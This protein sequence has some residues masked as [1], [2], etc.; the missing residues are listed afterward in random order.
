VLAELGMRVLLVDADLRKPTLHQLAQH[1]NAAGLSTAIATD[2]SWLEF[3]R[4]GDIEGLE[5][6]TAG[7]PPPNP[8]ALLDSPK[9]KQLV[10][11]WRRVYD[12]VLIDTPPIGAFA[13]AQSLG[14]QADSTIWIVG[15]GR[16]TRGALLQ[17]S[18]VLKR[19]KLAGFVANLVKKDRGDSVYFDYGANYYQNPPQNPRKFYLSVHRK[20]R[21]P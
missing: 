13:E 11:E 15:I 12:Y 19:G 16:S 18:E 8:V 20:N 21:K 3:V 10:G 6:L 1:S 9:M 7:P 17:T 2:R 14:D 4:I 5:I